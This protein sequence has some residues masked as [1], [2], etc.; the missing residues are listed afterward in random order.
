MIVATRVGILVSLFIVSMRLPAIGSDQA[1]SPAEAERYIKNSEAE[2]A[3]SVATNDTSVVKRILADDVVWV[4]DGRVLDKTRAV[5]EAEHGPSD[6]LSN[7][8]EYA[9]V[10][11]FGDTA[12]VQGSEKW[13]RKGGKIGR[14]VWT[15]TWLR[16]N[17]QWQIV[18]AEDVSVPLEK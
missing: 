12:V 9:H 2:W 10:R 7:T 11:F 5:A 18:A 3:A 17:G 8:L 13:T 14:F 1:Y 4:L 15:D 16:R 6:F